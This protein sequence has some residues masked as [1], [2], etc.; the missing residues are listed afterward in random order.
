MIIGARIEDALRWFAIHQSENGMWDV[1]QFQTNCKEG[2]SLCE[3]GKNFG[4]CADAACTALVLMCFL[5]A[6]YDHKHMSKWRNTVK[7][8]ID[9]LVAD[10]E[11]QGSWG[12]TCEEALCTMA[13]GRAYMFSGDGALKPSAQK[14]VDHLLELKVP[15]PKGQDSHYNGLGWSYRKPDPAR[16]DSVVSGFC[17]L[18][19]RFA[20]MGGVDTGCG[21]NHSV[22]W[23]TG[24]W[25]AANPDWEKLE[26]NGISRFP[27]TWDVTNGK[28]Q[29]SGVSVGGGDKTTDQRDLTVVGAMC[30][31]M[32]CKNGDPMKET[33]V[34]YVFRNQMPETYPC[35][36]LYLYYGTL[37]L[38][39][40]GGERW[41]RWK[42]RVQPLL[43]K[44]Q[45]QDLECFKGSW[46][47]ADT[48]FPG[49]QTGRLLSTAL[50]CLTLAT[51]LDGVYGIR[52]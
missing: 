14:A 30:A 13:L 26:V 44:A 21:L 33:L 42:E 23:L 50:C 16:M 1:D 32:L 48:R 51:C 29:M 10:Q 36:T 4:S 47:Y 49:H 46:D 37:A 12:S 40:T 3:P 2:G 15:D 19:L 35:N 17:T 8:G 7:K 18:A 52:P 20:R 27:Y 9:W 6:G 43:I 11:L 31:A 22:E 39:C 25:K 34:N 38:A 5:E 41:D 45:R 24:A 28:V